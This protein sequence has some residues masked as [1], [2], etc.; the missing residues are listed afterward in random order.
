VDPIV[1]WRRLV[2]A[3]RHHSAMDEGQV[4]I[5]YALILALIGLVT[6]GVLEALG[7]NISGVLT[8]VSSSMESVSNP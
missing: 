8:K 6:I 5:E 7:H 4:L 3:F 1:N 2:I